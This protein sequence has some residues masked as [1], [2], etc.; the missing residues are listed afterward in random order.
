MSKFKVQSSSQIQNSDVK[1]YLDF[2]LDLAFEF[3]HLD[4]SN[5]VGKDFPAPFPL[6][7]A[8]VVFLEMAGALEK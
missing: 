2:E 5:M 6:R 7:R 1:N 3:C 8:G 4:F